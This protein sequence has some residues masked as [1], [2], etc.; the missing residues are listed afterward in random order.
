M[1]TFSNTKFTKLGMAALLFAAVACS[2]D[3]NAGNTGSGD[4]L[5]SLRTQ[6]TE[7]TT[8]YVLRAESLL[9]GTIS[10]E[11]KGIEQISWC[12]Y[13]TFANSLFSISYAAPEGNEAIAYSLNA[14]GEL[15]ERGKFGFERLDCS[16]LADGNNMVGIGAPHSKP[17]GTSNRIMI[18]DGEKIMISANKE[19]NMYTKYKSGDI[20]EWPTGAVVRGSKLYI[21]F[22]PIDGPLWQTPITDT[23]YVNIYNY[24]SLE[25]VSTIK[26]TRMGPVGTYGSTP[27]VIKTENGDIYM[28]SSCALATGFTTSMKNSAILRMKNGQ[29]T[30]DADY[31]FDF[32]TATD[33]RIVHGSYVGNGKALVRYIPNESNTGQWVAMDPAASN[34][35]LAIVDLVNKTITDV[36]GVPLHGSNGMPFYYEDGKAIVPITSTA[37]NEV[38]IYAIDLTTGVATKGALVEGAELPLISKLTAE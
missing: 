17:N 11:G 27:A 20:N 33:A 25:F 4:Y 34:C 1:F 35:K 16:G 24:P 8:D 28:L 2:D 7:G 10:A 5:V 14:N 31:Y 3:D 22:Y 15:Y 38:R 23:C 9:E 21:P 18:I 36:T 32:Q 30:F 37:A 29:D 19:H 6:G 26:D 13:Q 12:Y